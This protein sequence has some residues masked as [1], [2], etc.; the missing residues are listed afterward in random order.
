MA[1]NTRRR[2]PSTSRPTP[3]NELVLQ[4]FAR[5]LYELMVARGWTQSELARRAFGTTTNKDGYTVA[6]GRDRIGVYIKGRSY[7]DPKNLKALADAFGMAPED[8]A[9]DITAAAI[10]REKPEVAIQQVPGQRGRV[11]LKVDMLVPAAL[12]AKVYALLAEAENDA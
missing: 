11:H 9:P 4:E 5:R 7:P 10:D 1:R 8:L 2:L 12:A 6:K 3:T